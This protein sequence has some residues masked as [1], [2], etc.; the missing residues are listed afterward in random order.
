MANYWYCKETWTNEDEIDFFSRLKRATKFHRPQYLKVQAYNFIKTKKI[1]LLNIAEKLLNMYLN[2]YPDDY[3]WKNEVFQ[4][5]GDIYKIRKN[6]EKAL[7]YYKLSVDV[8]G[9]NN[10]HT[11]SYIDYSELVLKN[12]KK[13]YYDFV[14]ILLEKKLKDGMIIF[15][16]HFYKIYIMLAI[17][18]R[19]KGDN[20]KSIV[21][22]NLSNNYS[23]MET[24]GL[25]YHKYLGIV[26]KEDKIFF[27]KIIKKIV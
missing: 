25:R 3:F 5:L 4:S 15:P 7:E 22:L 1:K 2:E 20:D 24:S 8:D 10:V 12:N 11:Y 6:E 17:L 9:V 18:N 14:E 13:E 16:M 26:K 23:G 21:Y 27:E 19:I